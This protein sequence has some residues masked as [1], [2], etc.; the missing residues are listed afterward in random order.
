[1]HGWVSFNA[2][3]EGGRAGRTRVSIV[4]FVFFCVF[5]RLNNLFFSHHTRALIRRVPHWPTPPPYAR[6][7]RCAM[8]F[9][10]RAAGPGASHTR[11]AQ[12]RLLTQ[13]NMQ[14]EK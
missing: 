10:L 3:A 4:V 1:V 13:A 8:N 12:A 9:L 2:C 11:K 14:E 5:V 7:V 6:V